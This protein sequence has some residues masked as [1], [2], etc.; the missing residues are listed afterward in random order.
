MT[1]PTGILMAIIQG[2]QASENFRG[3]ADSSKRSYVA[4]I[5][6]IEAKFGDSPLSALMDRHARGIFL[7]WRDK[8]AVESGRRQ[9]DYAWRCWP[10]F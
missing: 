7:E 10:A 8:I 9:A 5:K 4:L 3:L 2:Y 6:R 1:P